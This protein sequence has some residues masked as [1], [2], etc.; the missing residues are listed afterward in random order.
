[1]PGFIE[2]VFETVATL[3]QRKSEDLCYKE[4]KCKFQLKAAYTGKRSV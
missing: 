1:V 3:L 2:K 4:K